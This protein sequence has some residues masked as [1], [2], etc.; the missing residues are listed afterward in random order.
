MKTH[1]LAAFFLFVSLSYAQ[2]PVTGRA[3]GTE[4]PA[5]AWDDWFNARVEEFK[6]ANA[7]NKEQ[8]NFTIPVI[9]HVIHG[10]QPAGTFPNISQAQINSQ[11]SILNLDY[12]GF[13]LNVGNFA[14]TNFSSS[15]IANTN[16]NFC[17]AEK[18]PQGNLLAEKGIERISYIAKGW[19]NPTSFTS[20]NTFKTFI[21]NTVKANT[22]WDPAKY[23]NIWLTDVNGSVSLLG[24]ATFPPGTSLSGLAGLGGT[25]TDDGV[26]CWA[27][28]I[29]DVGSLTSF[30]NKGRTATHEIG[31]YLGLRHIWGDA[32]CGTDYCN[33]TPVQQ[34]DN[35]GC[36]TFP[37]VSCSNGPN[38]D[39]F[40]NFMDY[41]YDACMYMFTPDQ[42]TRMQTAMTNSPLRNQ[43]T[44]SA[45]N[46]CGGS[47]PVFCSD[48]LSNFLITDSLVAFRRAT[49]GAGDAQCLQ[50][51]GK[52]GYINGTN[53][54]GDKEKAEFISASKYAG[55]TNPVVTGVI[56][57]FFQYG[58]LG[59]DGNGSVGMNIYSGTSAASAPGNLLGSTSESLPTITAATNTASVHYCGNPNLGFSLPVI[60]PY[61]FNFSTPVY[62][63]ASG[64]FFASV[65]LPALAND[66]VAIMDKQTG[67]S[68]TAWEKWGDNS[69][70]DMKSAWGNARSFNLAILPVVECGPVSLSERA[71][72]SAG[73]FDLFPNPSNGKFYAMANFSSPSD[74]EIN[75]YN[76]LGQAVFS[77]KH[78]ASN[79]HLVEIDLGAH[80]NGI[81]FVELINGKEKQVKRLVLS[82]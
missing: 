10:G 70:H 68:N 58:N 32:S 39:L 42:R 16:I 44:A 21:D 77:N 63:P 1:F 53:C 18:D 67:T 41:T 25:A 71:A 31:H 29:G 36:P 12:S 50:G 28:A 19:A 81:Y 14:N 45:A 51:S 62:V 17:L 24:Y 30:Y 80:T 59:T 3:C 79:Q 66:T 69:W 15:L 27:R 73:N 11:I 33:D 46:L 61:K 8:A 7:A 4:A 75:V 9:F 65:V 37:K 49:A 54:Y 82:H 72:L 34:A 47:T 6:V 20:S 38:G 60:M 40:M 57:L 55:A 13:G 2:T 56:V 22:I 74:I 43:L 64:G 35:S 23:L 76:V 48:T 5:K 52:A 78:E 26:W